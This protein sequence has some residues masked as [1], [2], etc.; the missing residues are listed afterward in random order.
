MDRLAGGKDGGICQCGKVVFFFSQTLSNKIAR[1]INKKREKT[2]NKIKQCLDFPQIYNH[3]QFVTTLQQENKNKSSTNQRQPD[4]KGLN[5]SFFLLLFLLI[6]DFVSKWF[7]WV[8]MQCVCV[9]HF[10][11]FFSHEFYLILKSRVCFHF[12]KQFHS[13]LFVFLLGKIDST[14]HTEHPEGKGI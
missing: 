8:C 14:L 10:N 7:M 4:I 6:T 12:M 11:Q 1:D 9:L 2:E 3:K 5:L 13:I